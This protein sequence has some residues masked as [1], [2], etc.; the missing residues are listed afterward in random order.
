[1]L[2]DWLADTS[3]LIEAL[4]T[5]RALLLWRAVTTK[6]HGAWAELEG[7]RADLRAT[8]ADANRFGH[9]MG[10][11]FPVGVH[12]IEGRQLEELAHAHMRALLPEELPS[13]GAIVVDERNEVD[14]SERAVGID[15][16]ELMEHGELERLIKQR[17][18]LAHTLGY[19]DFYRLSLHAHQLDRV[20]WDRLLR[21]LESR[22]SYAVRHER[23]TPEV[24]KSSPLDG[25]DLV[26]RME[27]YFDAIGLRVHGVLRRS[28]LYPE[29]GTE[30][31][32]V[33]VDVDRL[34]D[35]RIHCGVRPAWSTCRRFLRLL[36]HAVY[37]LNV[38]NRLPFLLRRAPHGILLD[39]SG[40]L[41][42]RL[43]YRAEWFEEWMGLSSDVAEEVVRCLPSFAIDGRAVQKIRLE[44]AVYTTPVNRLDAMFGT[45]WRAEAR[46]LLTRPLVYH[47]HVL[48]ELIASSMEAGV[49][50]ELGAGALIG[51]PAAGYLLI[52][53]VYYHG[54]RYRWDVLCRRAFG[55]L[56]VVSGAIIA[57]E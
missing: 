53:Q 27:Q 10:K 9:L 43:S 45:G 5:R 17:N 7:A 13:V 14:L 11:S 23:S 8:L 26:D 35:V 51:S 49:E 6:E 34:G 25:V 12:P 37:A 22:A 18:A 47:R 50:E 56:D 46:A 20:D 4:T 52:D 19:P 30:F 42:A 55:G 33:Y 39:A 28:R 29:Y 2:T 36:G 41:F 48:A 31:P 1:M 21:T 32:A 54:A 40:R 15:S 44:Q 24:E 38:F 3:R 16:G 57:K